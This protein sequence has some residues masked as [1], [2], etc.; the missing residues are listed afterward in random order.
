MALE[1]YAKNCKTFCYFLQYEFLKILWIISGFMTAN[2]IMKRLVGRITKYYLF[3]FLMYYS[4]INKG[5]SC[6]RM[7]HIIDWNQYIL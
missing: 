4:N 3:I 5:F 6:F 1:T 2:K 7:T